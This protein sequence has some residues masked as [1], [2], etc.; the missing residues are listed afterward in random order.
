MRPMKSPKPLS[1]EQMTQASYGSPEKDDAWGRHAGH[2]HY[3]I[4]PRY[5]VVP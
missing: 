2:P 4:D 1:A 5:V 3:G